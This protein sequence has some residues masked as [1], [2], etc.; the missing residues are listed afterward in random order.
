MN[1]PVLLLIIIFLLGLISCENK[2]KE[3]YWVVKSK[4]KNDS[5]EFVRN[6]KINKLTDSITHLSFLGFELGGSISEGIRENKNKLK[7]KIDGS[8]NEK[9][10]AFDSYLKLLPTEYNVNR[11]IDIS[12]KVCSYLDTITS[13]IMYTNQNVYRNIIDLYVGKYG[14]AYTKESSTNS[15]S[16]LWTFKNQSIRI[17]EFTKTEEKIVIKDLTKRAAKNRYAVESSIYFVGLSI[18]YTDFNQVTKL[19]LVKEKERRINRVQADSLAIIAEY[20]KKK[21]IEKN[22]KEALNQ[23][24]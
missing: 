2:N 1:K 6:S 3:P 11:K 5:I 13:L 18:I 7:F 23:D 14:D 16:V 17:T 15:H 19:K 20:E 9:S 21:D 8:N 10:V 22:N 4:I 12:V 24:F